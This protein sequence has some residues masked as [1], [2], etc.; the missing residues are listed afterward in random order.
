[1]SLVVF[2][3]RHDDLDVFGRSIAIAA[4]HPATTSVLCVGDLPPRTEVVAEAIAAA[5]GAAPVEVVEQDRIGTLR[6]GKGD[7]MLSGVR[8]NPA[9]IRQGPKT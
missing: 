3:F 1:M 6:P 2:P 8:V 5:G 9:T 4:S 7:A